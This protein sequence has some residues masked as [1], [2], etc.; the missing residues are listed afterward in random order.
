MLEMEKLVP[1]IFVKEGKKGDV[2][3]REQANNLIGKLVSVMDESLKFNFSHNL[4]LW[5]K[6]EKEVFVF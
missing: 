3:I 2:G 1:I 6:D 4:F 5:L